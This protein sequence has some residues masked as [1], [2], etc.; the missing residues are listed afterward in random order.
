[1]KKK[2]K[3]TNKSDHVTFLLQQFL[4]SPTFLEQHL[5]CPM[6]I[7]QNISF[8]GCQQLYENGVQVKMVFTA[9]F[10]SPVIP[11]VYYESLKG[12]YRMQHFLNLLIKKAFWFFGVFFCKALRELIF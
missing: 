6:Y 4:C 2:W 5:V 9:I 7:L 12:H 1:M 8:E 3:G 11:N 10:F